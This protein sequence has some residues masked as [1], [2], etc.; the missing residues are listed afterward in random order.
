[1]DMFFLKISAH[2]SLKL[3]EFIY[4]KIAQIFNCTTQIN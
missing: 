2:L 3:K 1:L 4:L